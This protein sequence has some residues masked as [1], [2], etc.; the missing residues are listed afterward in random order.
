MESDL[1]VGDSTV[2][3]LD[4]APADVTTAVTLEVRPPGGPTTDVT[5]TGG[6]LVEIADT[7]PQQYSQRWTADDPVSYDAAG[8]WVLHYDVTGTGEGA[9]DVDVW[10]V[11]SPTGSGP[12]W[13]PGRS[14]VAAYVPHRTL[15][16]STTTTTAGADTYELT[17]GDDTIPSGTQ[18]DRLIAD[19]V[20]WVTA[21]V[22]PLNVRSEPLAAIL[23]ATWAAVSVERSW[24]DGDESLQRANDM[25]KRLDRLLAALIASNAAAN[26]ED[27]DEDGD[28]G[29]DYVPMYDPWIA[30]CD[31]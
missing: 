4:V 9:E 29:F 6:T 22:T 5:M 23:A 17:F 25:E 30:A 13:A 12:T 10:V 7:S 20:D 19:G 3:F 14:R 18:V 26:G 1:G 31:P 15:L 16:R 8:H 21:L 11:P 28:F 2:P 27:D 24:P